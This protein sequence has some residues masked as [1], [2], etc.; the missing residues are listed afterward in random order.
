VQ[1]GCKAIICIATMTDILR[2]ETRTS[3]SHVLR[4]ACGITE[5]GPVTETAMEKAVPGNLRGRRSAGQS[6]ATL[7]Y[8]CHDSA[9]ES[10]FKQ[11]SELT[12]TVAWVLVA[13]V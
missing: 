11:D 1:V 7:R 10:M 8:Q 3:S 6:L 12:D 13:K 9:T 5:T 2:P 4:L